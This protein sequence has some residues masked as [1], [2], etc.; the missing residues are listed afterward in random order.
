MLNVNVTTTLVD[1]LTMIGTVGAL[2]IAV[3]VFTRDA[4]WRRREQTYGQA[5][6]ISAW[7]GDPPPNSPFNAGIH[8]HNGS[9]S[10]I[11]SIWVYD[12][13]ERKRLH[14]LDNVVPPGRTVIE[15]RD[16]ERTVFRHIALQIEFTD[17]S[18]QVWV[19]EKNG[20]LIPQDYTE[21]GYQHKKIPPRWRTRLLARLKYLKAWITIKRRHLKLRRQVKKNAKAETRSMNHE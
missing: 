8:I 13:S 12:G 6:R 7:I 9:D 11:Y 14:T 17:S 2:L 15:G 4:W 3:G 19:K 5:Q 10:M 1:V 20:Q 18:G 16:Y 21:H